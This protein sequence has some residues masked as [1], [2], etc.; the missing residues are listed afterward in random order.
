MTAVR[1]G[2]SGEGTQ[3]DRGAFIDQRRVANLSPLAGVLAFG[4][5]AE[6][7]AARAGGE[8]RLLRV[9]LLGSSGM[10]SAQ[11]RQAARARDHLVAVVEQQ[12]VHAQM[13]RE[14]VLPEG[15]AR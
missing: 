10:F 3:S 1:L 14:L 8:L 2:R 9:F 11:R 4:D 12:K 15:I 13:R 7:P 6:F 5:L